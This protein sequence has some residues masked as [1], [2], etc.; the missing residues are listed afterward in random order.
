MLRRWLES[1]KAAAELPRSMNPDAA[2][3][4]ARGG[5]K[6][7]FRQAVSSHSGQTRHPEQDHLSPA[8]GEADTGPSGSYSGGLEHFSGGPL[9]SGSGSLPT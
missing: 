9:R 6:A 8:T 7:D 5:T 1:V 4:M 3:P 2:Q